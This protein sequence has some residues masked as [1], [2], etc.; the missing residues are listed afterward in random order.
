MDNAVPCKKVEPHWLAVTE[1]AGGLGLFE[2][3]I[4]LGTDDEKFISDIDQVARF[5]SLRLHFALRSGTAITRGIHP[6]YELDRQFRHVVATQLATPSTIGSQ[7][8]CRAIIDFTRT[9]LPQ[10]SGKA[11]RDAFAMGYRLAYLEQARVQAS[12]HP[13]DS[14]H[15]IFL[16]FKNHILTAL[17]KPWIVPSDCGGD[18]YAEIRD[19]YPLLFFWKNKATSI[20][21]P[22]Y[23][24]K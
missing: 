1:L 8:D 2:I 7:F 21:H 13:I 9:C 18:Y 23:A 19:C 3:P 6:R 15:P 10:I 20:V 17:G 14:L 22:D 4:R 11:A 5:S 12:E 16:G 24:P